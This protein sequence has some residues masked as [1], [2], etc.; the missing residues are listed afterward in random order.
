LREANAYYSPAKKALLLG[1]FTTPEDEAS[2][3][4]MPG[5]MVFTAL[6]HDVIAHETAHALLDGM[7]RRLGQPTNQD[8]LAFHEAFADIVALFQHFTFPEVMKHEMARTRGDIGMQ[9][10]SLAQLAAQFGRAIGSHG[11]LRDFIGTFDEST[12]KW[13][14]HK[15]SPLDIEKETEPHARGAILVAAVFDAFIAIYR[16]RVQDL[17]R[18]YTSGTGV[19]PQGEIHPDLV[20]RLS[21]EATKAANHVLTM[22]I[23]SLDY[24]PPVDLTFGE[25]LRAIITADYDQYPEDVHDYRVAFVEAF[26]R[27]GIYPR[28]VRTLSAENLRWREPLADA[29]QASASF[30][31]YLKELRK[32]ADAHLYAES[33]EA[34]F[35]LER[36]TREIIHEWLADHFE[37]H[38]N[39][40]Q[41]AT[42]LGL[43]PDHSFE[44]HSAHFARHTDAYEQPTVQLIMQLVQEIKIPKD[45]GSKELENF[46]GGCT[47]IADL[48]AAD[49]SYCVRKPV[50]STTR[51]QRQQAF[52][53]RWENESLRATYFSP[54]NERPTREPF[55]IL[56]R[57]TL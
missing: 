34:L 27:R 15:P 9:E 26:R 49:V 3:D 25:Y 28:D 40:R 30:L 7:N 33:R 41:D 48:I 52:R 46:S 51:R 56:H 16:S 39:G 50:D 10:N 18:L 32:Y 47:L 11:A 5:S 43:D 42:F 36:G 23:R 17:L 45:V 2:S 20:N 22:C 6:S 14:L 54:T 4:H 1:Y 31:D 37:N 57:D 24:C 44:V 35:N 29:K 12:K 55:A 8:M 19:L 38:K 53:M 13:Q 21:D